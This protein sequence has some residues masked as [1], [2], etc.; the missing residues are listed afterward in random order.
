MNKA[1]FR[2]HAVLITLTFWSASALGAQYYARLSG[3]Q[4]VP[5]T[6]SPAT[7]DCSVTTVGSTVSVSCEFSGLEAA[8][9]ASHIHGAPAGSNGPVL[10]GLTPTLATS[11][12][13]SGGGT[14]SDE[15]LEA[16]RSGETYINLHT[17]AH[18]A[19]E[20]RGQILQ[21]PTSAIP[22]LSQWGTL[23]AIL[24]LLVAGGLAIRRFG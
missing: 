12:V 10:L 18:P 23:T 20:I 15:N 21:V 14:L 4:E 16:L 17:S 6:G 19:G 3:D 2:V 24:A 11:G 22:T 13:I 8:A 5:G 7:G 1:R 9:T